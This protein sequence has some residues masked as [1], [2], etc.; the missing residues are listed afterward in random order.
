LRKPSG[1]W[2]TGPSRRRRP[3]RICAPYPLTGVAAL[4]GTAVKQAIEVAVQI[5]NTPHPGLP[6]LPL[7]ATLLVQL[8]GKAYVS[9]WPDKAAVQ[10]PA[11]PFK[12]WS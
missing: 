12:G 10:P 1:C 6:N 11:L 3:V 7:T 9:V 2:S 8:R 5:M 4:A